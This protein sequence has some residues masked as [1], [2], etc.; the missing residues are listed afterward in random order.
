M[1][2]KEIINLRN[3]MFYGKIALKVKLESRVK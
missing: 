2:I 1:W 3:G